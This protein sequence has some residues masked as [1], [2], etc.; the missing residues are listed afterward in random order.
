MPYED[1]GNQSYGHQRNPSIY[2]KP[3][4]DISQNGRIGLEDTFIGDLF[5]ADGRIGAQGPGMAAS[6]Q[7]A[8][9]QKAIEI[10]QAQ[11]LPV[12]EQNVQQVM[13]MIDEPA[14][15]EPGSTIP[16]EVTT[17]VLPP[18]DAQPTQDGAPIDPETGSPLPIA[19]AAAAGAVAGSS[20]VRRNSRNQGQ[21]STNSDVATVDTTE[22]QHQ[23]RKGRDAQ[24][25]A[26]R[27]R[28][29]SNAVDVPTGNAGAQQFAG[30]T[31]TQS[32]QAYTPENAPIDDPLSDA[33]VTQAPQTAPNTSQRVGTN[34][35]GG[36]ID[37][38]SNGTFST[39]LP[40]GQSVKADSLA[41]LRAAIRGAM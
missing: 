16:P 35:F 15:A 6:L 24:L 10:V 31:A 18:A 27:N 19:G 39:T 17:S 34:E 2:D 9:R 32:P 28:S 37:V 41:A 26:A 8:R 21:Q 4:Q 38:D 20:A 22:G 1:G 29:N 14:V 23:S 33:P 25:E 12:T 36:G 13:P 11:G 3:L 30:P 40:N 5:G 7:G